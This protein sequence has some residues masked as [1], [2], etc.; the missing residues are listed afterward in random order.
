MAEDGRDQGPALPARVLFAWGDLRGSIR[1]LLAR[2]P[3]EGFLLMLALVSGVFSFMERMLRLWSN[4]ASAARSEDALLAEAS[5]EF[6]AAMV[7]RTLALYAVA[8]VAWLLSRSRG[9]TGTARATR[10]A[11]FWSALIAGPVGL[12]AALVE[13]AIAPLVP[14]MVATAIGQTGVAAY[15][16][17]AATTTAE[18]HGFRHTW[19]VLAA[20]VAAVLAI[21][22]VPL[23][24]FAP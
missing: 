11:W 10:A 4:P 5:G 17:A 14:A 18:V 23:L 9:G 6:M 7:F 12:A 1:W 16:L 20:I 24:L 21:L 22:A 15:A 13:I 8:A 2:D 3:S 19:T